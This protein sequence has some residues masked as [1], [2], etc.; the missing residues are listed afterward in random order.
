M[1]I[2][3]LA[4]GAGPVEPETPEVAPAPTGT[5]WQADGWSVRIGDTQLTIEIPGPKSRLVR[6]HGEGLERLDRGE[7]EQLAFRVSDVQSGSARDPASFEPRLST[8]L[9]NTEFR[10]G[11]AVQLH[12]RDLTG[13]HPQICIGK[14]CRDVRKV[15]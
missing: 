12:T 1:L 13:E 9:E 7:Y 5:H 4:C 14:T 2:A 3:M 15:P 6:I 11:Y 8:T 10:A